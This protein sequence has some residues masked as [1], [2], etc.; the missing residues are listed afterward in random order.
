MAAAAAAAGVG[1]GFSIQSP[2]RSVQI[3]W[4]KPIASRSLGQ[5]FYTYYNLTQLID[6]MILP[7]FVNGPIVVNRWLNNY[8]LLFIASRS[9]PEKKKKKRKN[10]L[11]H[12]ISVDYGENAMKKKLIL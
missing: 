5:P 1:Y 9:T 11:R 3:A 6:K 4:R 8:L 7:H 10:A 2:P 12:K